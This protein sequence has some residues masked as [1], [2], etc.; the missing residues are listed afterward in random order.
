M[1][2]S[3]LFTEVCESISQQVQI[4]S[5]CADIL[6]KKGI[7]RVVNNIR[8]LQ[9]EELVKHCKEPYQWTKGLIPGDVI[10]VEVHVT[11]ENDGLEVVYTYTYLMVNFVY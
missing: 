8:L 3:E 11:S 5:F 7:F 6:E 10:G 1:E 4:T 9:K 2:L